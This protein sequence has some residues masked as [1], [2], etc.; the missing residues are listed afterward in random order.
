MGQ[1]VNLRTARKQ[2]RRRQAAEQ[3]QQGRLKHGRSKAELTL[4]AAR[5]AKAARDLDGH[6]VDDEGDDP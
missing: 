4:A 5:A 6:R 1:V 3:A 2:A